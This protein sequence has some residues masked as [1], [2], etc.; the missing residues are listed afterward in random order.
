MQKKLVDPGGIGRVFDGGAFGECGLESSPMLTVVSEKEIILQ[1][2]S[3]N[4]P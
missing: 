3:S 1:R 2:F 4:E